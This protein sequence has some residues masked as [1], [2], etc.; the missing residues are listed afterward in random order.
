MPQTEKH[1]TGGPTPS[2]SAIRTFV[3]GV[4]SSTFDHGDVVEIT[5]RPGH[6]GSDRDSRSECTDRSQIHRQ[7]DHYDKRYSL[8]HDSPVSFSTD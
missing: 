3:S 7:Q 5:T 4:Q 2:F 6:P 1:R 8:D